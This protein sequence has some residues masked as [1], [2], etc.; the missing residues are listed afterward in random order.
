MAVAAN[1]IESNVAEAATGLEA[2]GQL[3]MRYGL[4]LV[5]GWIWSLGKALSGI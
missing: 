4:V 5:V 1:R 3:I 2:A